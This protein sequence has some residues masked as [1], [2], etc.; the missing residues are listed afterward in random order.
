[1]HRLARAEEMAPVS[2]SRCP[3]SRTHP[4]R[5]QTNPRRPREGHR[6]DSRAHMALLKKSPKRRPSLLSLFSR[7]LPYDLPLTFLFARNS[8]R[9]AV[10][11]AGAWSLYSQDRFLT[12]M[13]GFPWLFHGV[14]TTGRKTRAGR[15]SFLAAVTVSH[16]Q[17][18]MSLTGGLGPRST[19]MPWADPDEW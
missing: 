10:F 13:T 4:S 16:A 3:S 11:T 15:W 12:A 9:R 19:R 18:R 5:Y 1:M 17:V 7:S 2:D 6:P 8:W 14:R